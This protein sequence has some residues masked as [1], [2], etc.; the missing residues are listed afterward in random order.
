MDFNRRARK[1]KLKEMLNNSNF[2]VNS[3]TSALPTEHVSYVYDVL[4]TTCSAI[5]ESLV[6]S[7]LCS[8]YAFYKQLYILSF[9]R[10]LHRCIKPVDLATKTTS[11][12]Q[13]CIWETKW[14][15][16]IVWKRHWNDTFN[17]ELSCCHVPSFTRYC[18]LFLR[19]AKIILNCFWTNATVII[20]NFRILFIGEMCCIS[21]HVGR[22]ESCSNWNNLLKYL[23]VTFR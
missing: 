9:Y 3:S 11:D 19:C 18:L 12:P 6:L 1:R 17:V 22:N 21:R 14:A 8:T 5:V 10:T 15:E 20:E 7:V 16:L 13:K 4:S 23:N 2:D